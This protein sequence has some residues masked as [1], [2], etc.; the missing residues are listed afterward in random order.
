[1]TVRVLPS[2]AAAVAAVLAL[3]GCAMAPVQGGGVVTEPGGRPAGQAH[4]VI[5]QQPSWPTAL[6]TI[7]LPGGD[8]FRGKVIEERTEPSVGF[9]V[10]TGFG[11]GHRR[12]GYGSGMM[13]EG[14]ERTS[15]A[16][17]LLIS[18]RGHSMTCEL[19]LASPGY[20]GG[21]GFA[22][23]KVSDGRIVALQF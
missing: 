9:G 22:D 11:W 14:P 18:D 17:A 23:C 21:G 6:A 8:Q 2:A 3:A 16:S 13:F 7:T 20:L 12:G 5:E 4:M 15:R 10:A 1:M 19:R